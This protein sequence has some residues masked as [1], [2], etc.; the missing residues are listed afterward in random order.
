MKQ[1][2][3]ATC[4]SAKPDEVARAMG[5][6]RQEYQRLLGI[7][8]TSRSVS[9]EQLQPGQIS[10]SELPCD[11]KPGPLDDLQT[12][13]LRQAVLRAITRLPQRQK[14]VLALY[15]I[16]E[17][18]LREIGEILDLSESRVC[19]IHSEALMH[20]RADLGDAA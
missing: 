4:R 12:R 10:A 3:N 16:E 15:Y 6:S 5:L 9:F 17:K 8:A 19:Q 13:D 1:V 20:V 2:E 14:L 7:C 18:N 11:R